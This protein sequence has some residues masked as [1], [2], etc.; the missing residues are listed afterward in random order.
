MDREEN[1][2]WDPN[3]AASNLAKHGISFET[4]RK[5]FYDYLA[6][7]LLDRRFD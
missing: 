3:K 7:D 4:A 6:I 2:E 5:A 1:F